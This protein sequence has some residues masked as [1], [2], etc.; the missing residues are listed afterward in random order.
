SGRIDTPEEVAE[1]TVAAL[2]GTVPAE[3]AGIVF[4]SGGQTP[5]Q[6]T[7]NLAAIVR[8]AREMRAPWP[9]TFSYARAIQEDAL[10][11]WKGEV[12][13]VPAAREAYLARLHALQS[14]LMQ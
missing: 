11:I 12:A 3:V 5:D 14:A 13:N 2:M 8:R 4:L 6:A 1:D 10:A 7:A 9:V